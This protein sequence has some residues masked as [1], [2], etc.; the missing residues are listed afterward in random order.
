M[1]FFQINS[2]AVRV[3]TRYSID[4]VTRSAGS[5]PTVTWVQ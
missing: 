1:V 5:R 2:N 4:L 3:S